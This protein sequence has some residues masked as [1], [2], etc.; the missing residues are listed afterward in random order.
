[1]LQIE[2]KLCRFTNPFQKSMENLVFRRKDGR[3][4][5]KANYLEYLKTHCKHTN[6]QTCANSFET[7]RSIPVPSREPLI[8]QYHH[9]IL[10]AE[11]LKGYIASDR[12]KQLFLGGTVFNNTLKA[13]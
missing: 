6:I 10:N 5:Y 4:E 3:H 8:P 13:M 2:N 9:S 11:I 7:S 12:D 1:M